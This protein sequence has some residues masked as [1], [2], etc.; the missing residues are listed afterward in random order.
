MRAPRKTNPG[1]RGGKV[2]K[3][4]WDGTT[5]NYWDHEPSEIV[6]ERRR[7]GAG[8]RHFVTVDEIRRF[9]ALIPKWN[10]VSKGLRAIVFVPFNPFWYGRYNCEGILQ[11]SAWPHELWLEV[12]KDNFERDKGLFE[13]LKIEIEDLPHGHLIKPSEGQVKAMQLLGT[14]LHELGH[15]VDRMNSRKRDNC[16]NG[17]PFALAYES[18]WR[19]RLYPAYLRE[20]KL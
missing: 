1:V 19:E 12:G 15:H 2:Q 5:H 4:N 13:L 14:F 6:I 3:K 20:F 8:F 11:V 7:P 16:H 17:E 18:E 9:T 10:E